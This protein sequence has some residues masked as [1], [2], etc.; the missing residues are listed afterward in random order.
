MIRYEKTHQFSKWLEL[1][2]K[3]IHVS[4]EVAFALMNTTM[5]DIMYNNFINDNATVSQSN[6]RTRFSVSA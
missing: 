4:D 1:V 6:F 3:T 5:N 2:L